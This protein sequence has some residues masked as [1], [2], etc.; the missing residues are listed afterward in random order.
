MALK[1][2]KWDV[3]KLKSF[4]TAEAVSKVRAEKWKMFASYTSDKRLVSRL[5]K[6]LK[7]KR[8]D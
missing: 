8:P 1:I 5:Y 3:I 2:D 4:S 7:N 6:D